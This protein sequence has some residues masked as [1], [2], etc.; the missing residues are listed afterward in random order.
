MPKLKLTAG[1]TWM[2]WF[3]AITLSGTIAEAGLQIHGLSL[4]YAYAF[5]IFVIIL[6]VGV[7]EIQENLVLLQEAS[8][9]EDDANLQEEIDQELNGR[10]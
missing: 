1:Q 2:F 9:P 7:A 4:G 5:M 8:E 3:V 6:A 10:E